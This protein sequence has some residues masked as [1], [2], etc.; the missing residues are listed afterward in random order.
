MKRYALLSL[1]HGA[2]RVIGETFARS[3]QE[4]I[5]YFRKLHP[6]LGLNAE[7]YAKNM[8]LTYCIAE[9]Y[10]YSTH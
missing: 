5:N 7:G 10:E 4:A 8:D 6:V 2:N 9:Y 3:T 1:L